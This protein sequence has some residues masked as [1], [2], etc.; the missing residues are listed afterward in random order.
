M[1]IAK[2]REVSSQDIRDKYDGDGILRCSAHVTPTG[3]IKISVGND[4]T[5]HCIMGW[6][7]LTLKED[8]RKQIAVDAMTKACEKA[9][10]SVFDGKLLLSADDMADEIL[11]LRK[12]VAISKEHIDN[13]KEGMKSLKK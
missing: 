5:T 3:D 7:N 8:Y 6:H 10:A 9:G 11:S 1:A 13:R 4:A 12:Q 2:D